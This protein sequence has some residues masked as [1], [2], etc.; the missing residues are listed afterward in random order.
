MDMESDTDTGILKQLDLSENNDMEKCRYYL[1][2]FD[3]FCSATNFDNLVQ[4]I[5]SISNK[6]P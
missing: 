4:Y 6:S 2:P 5:V 1:T 3:I